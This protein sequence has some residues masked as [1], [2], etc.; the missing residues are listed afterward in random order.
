[1][2][3][4]IIFLYFG[5][6]SLIVSGNVVH[7]RLLFYE[8]DVEELRSRIFNEKEP[9]ILIYNQLQC[10]VK[11]HTLH[12]HE[13][14]DDVRMS[15]L[16]STTRMAVQYAFVGMVEKDT[17][18]AIEAYKVFDQIRRD[19]AG[20]VWDMRSFGLTRAQVL[21]SASYV[22][23]F[24][25][26]LLTEEQRRHLN[27]F[28]LDLMV[29]VHASMGLE[30]NYATESNWQGVR[31]GSV[32]L[33]SIAY[34]DVENECHH[35]PFKWDSR[36]RLQDH[37]HATF[38]KNGWNV[39]S[40]GYLEYNFSFSIPAL[41]AQ[42]RVHPGLDAFDLE[43][44][45]PHAINAF[46][47]HATANVNIPT[48]GVNLTKADFS[49]DHN[50]SSYVLYP[51]ALKIMPEEQLPYLYWMHDYVIQKGIFSG[52][53]PYLIY[54]LMFYEENVPKKNPEEA[55]W[56]NYVCDVH[57]VLLM[58]NCFQ[59]KND[60]VAGMTVTAQRKDGHNG[61][62]NLSF[63]IYGLDGLWAVGGGRTN[64][65]AA[66]TNLFPDVDIDTVKGQAVE[67]TLIDYHVEDDGSGFIIGEGSCAGVIGHRRY[68]GTSFKEDA[69]AQA[70][71]IVADV[72][73]NGHIWRMSTPEFNEVEVLEDGF[74]IKG[75]KGA[76]LRARVMSSKG[77]EFKHQIS[78]GKARY[79]GSVTRHNRG[80][81]FY[82]T[83]YEHVKT[84]DVLC[85]GAITVVMTLVKEG[86]EHPVIK[87]TSQNNIQ[88]GKR[89]LPEINL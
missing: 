77:K 32:L 72:S 12:W 68:F 74:L 48:L 35:L 47:A 23:D 89:V 52:E 2:R 62:D 57:G 20:L 40:L 29:F 1:M 15:K 13:E 65:M 21:Q 45:V 7:P 41:I 43:K 22:Y 84:I 78:I 70:T 58:R 64:E 42:Q 51:L 80:V 69:G 6:V 53:H 79:G 44:F 37:L 46:R 59:D 73:E 49:D 39:E 85:D 55:G 76:S 50:R 88:V 5:I 31:Y 54:G 19:T 33:A 27:S 86:E 25:Y 26:S 9:Y 87:H 14:D 34:D 18:L 66:Q 30:G 83:C 17:A 63:R 36:R 82:D 67:G 10:N 61:P 81:C 71:F 60:I 16:Y 3:Y 11:T 24:V 4:L 75:P 28:I 56:L 38:T 8:S